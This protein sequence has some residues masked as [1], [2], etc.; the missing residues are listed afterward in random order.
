[1]LRVPGSAQSLL[2]V[3]AAGGDVRIVYS[4]L[5]AREAG[6]RESRARRWSSSPSAS[7][8]PRRPTR[9]R[10]GRRRARGLTNFSILV[11]HVLVPPAM[12]AILA[13]ARQPR[14]GLPR[15][16]PRL[17]GD[18]L[19]TSTSRSPS[20]TACRSWSPASS[21]SICCEGI[22]MAVAQLEAGRA[23]GREPVRAR[24]CAARATGRRRRAIAEVFEVGDR[25][26]ARHRRDSRRA[27]CGCASAY[28]A[29]RRRARASTSAAIA[30]RRVGRVHRGRGAAGP[31]EAARVPG[32]RHALHARA[33]AGRADGLGRGRLRGLLPIRRR[34]PAD[35]GDRRPTRCSGPSI[36]D[37][38]VQLAH[39]GGG[40]LTQQLIERIFLPAFANPALDGAARR[41]G[42][43]R[44]AS[45]R[46]AF[47]TDSLR[48]APAVL[49]RRRHRRRWPSTARSTTS[50]CAARGRCAL[51]AGFILEEGLPLRD[52]ATRGR[53][54]CGRPPSAAGVH[55]RHRRHQGRRSRQGR[56]RLHQHRR[57]R[58]GRA[59]ASTIAP[60]RRAA[61]RRHDLSAATSAAHGI[62]ILSVREGLEF[63]AP[64]DSDSRA[65]V[66]PVVALLAAGIDV[67]CL[68]DLTRGGLAA[69]L[70]EIATTGARRHPPRGGALSP[71]REA[72]RGACEI[73]GLDPL[74]VANEGRFVAVRA[75][76]AA[77]EALR[78]LGTSPSRGTRSRRPGRGG[79]RRQR[80]HLQQPDRR[81][82]RRRSV[83]RRAASADRQATRFRSLSP[84]FN[85][86]PTGRRSSSRRH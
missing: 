78:V 40:R 73:L 47:T 1:M 77:D 2:D 42:A 30:R 68:R 45:A 82:P 37:D 4:P 49:P 63:E 22:Y 20:G 48:R 71:S 79:G 66:G 50:R 54:R 19:P 57:H 46:L 85:R 36:A 8:P 33:S 53:R 56:R 25:A 11:S 62:A 12:E 6:A 24:R 52:A 3:K 75:G 27:A 67:H 60:A 64:I 9:W 43:R 38:R 84:K 32:V 23:R 44:R 81:Q 86:A 80:G 5:D 29:L 83:Q 39:G 28:P 69:A 10:S 16:R 76:R 59:D 18:G 74:Y 58:R 51:S 41:R 21:R 13:F 17:H 34:Q 65:A 7:R 61:R 35:R 15:R 55:D 31:Q 72:V 26:V 14:A 70:C